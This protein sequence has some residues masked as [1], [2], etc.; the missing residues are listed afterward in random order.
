L[1]A[2]GALEIVRERLK[3]EET[4]SDFTARF[5]TPHLQCVAARQPGIIIRRAAFG[6]N[7]VSHDCSG[8]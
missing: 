2:N 3:T 5:V 1:R 7:A 6:S 4:Y 8:V